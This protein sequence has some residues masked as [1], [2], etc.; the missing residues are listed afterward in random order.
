MFLLL[1]LGL[2]LRR[3]NTMAHF[4]LQKAKVV[5]LFQFFTKN[6]G[7]SRLSVINRDQT[8]RKQL[9][10]TNFSILNRRLIFQLSIQNI[11]FVG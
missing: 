6:N 10:S 9:F 2:D 3:P 7:F 1:F 4:C 8:D 11:I 5:I